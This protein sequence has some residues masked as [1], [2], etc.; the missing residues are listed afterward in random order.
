[1]ILLEIPKQTI[2][3][4]L[5][6]LEEATPMG[7]SEIYAAGAKAALQWAIDRRE[8]PTEAMLKLFGEH[9]VMH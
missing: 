5:A 4:E 1:M 7:F 9:E 3:L 2:L 8:S 6:S